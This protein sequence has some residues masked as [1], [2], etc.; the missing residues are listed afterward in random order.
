MPQLVLVPRGKGKPVV[1]PL[2]KKI[3][4]IGR[5]GENDVVLDLPGVGTCHAH[6]LYDGKHFVLS[7]ADRNCEVLV[8]G[9]RRKSHQLADQDSLRIGPAQLS[10]SLFDEVTA[11]DVP[12][13]DTVGEAALEAMEKLEAFSQRLFGTYEIDK[14]LE[15]L[16][17]DVIELS[18]ADKGFLI[19]LD[20]DAPTVRVARNIERKTLD[21]NQVAFSDSIVQKVLKSRRPIIVSDALH[22]REFSG[23][24]SIINLRLCSVM[25][26]PLLTRGELL[27]LIYVGN[28]NI[29][30]LFRPYQLDV[31]RVFGSQAALIIAN[32]LLV[33][34]LKIDK[35]R[36]EKELADT[37]YGEIIGS[38]DSMRDIYAKIDKIATT[39]ISVLIDGETGTGKELIAKE[40]HKRSNRSRGPFV[41]INCGA[42]PENLLESELFGHVRGAFT[43][44]I[45]TTVGK[46]QAADGGTLFLDEVGE[47]PM[48]LQVKLLRAI[49]ERQIT[50]V[51]EARA[52]NIDI[53][54]LAATNRDLQT[55]VREGRFRE[56]LYYRMNVVKLTLPPLR[57]RGDDVV[58]I[59]RYL[60]ARF[61]KEFGSKV[62]GFSPEA[63]GELRRYAWPGNIR[64]LEN[65]IKKAIVFSDGPFIGPDTLEF[66]VGELKAILPLDQAK[67]Q[68]QRE[69]I[70]EVLRLNNGNRTK[71]AKD[72]EVDPRTI[73]RHLEKERDD[74]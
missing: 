48:T 59:A 21:T 71:T 46:F 44:A 45:A 25:S 18:K 16:M 12:S 39:D 35:Q 3:T 50:R 68:F 11:D 69:Y 29:V 57:E 1:F 5:A 15:Q 28:D 27:G 10:F 70:N 72:L 63:I 9:R 7:E 31:L 38:C 4:T 60:L 6:I 33:N 23:S 67:D 2:F 56:D 41:T 40:I 32:A 42:I 58:L 74:E 14:L 13:S 51:G 34:D 19:L 22:D 17:D 65:R 8:N 64:E 30:N 66:A 20:G 73:F 55:E 36:L 62:K 24:T 26:V 53:R 61:A 43:G 37:R 47:M 52:T 49:Q 54:I